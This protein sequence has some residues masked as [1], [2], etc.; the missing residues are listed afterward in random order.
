MI[1]ENGKEI[2]EIWSLGKMCF[3]PVVLDRLVVDDLGRPAIVF[4][5]VS[6]GGD[7]KARCIRGWTEGGN[8]KAIH[9]FKKAVTDFLNMFGCEDCSVP[10]DIWKPEKT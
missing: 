6:P 1:F 3:D 7:W 9:S 4:A 8:C 10:D 2:P 5:L